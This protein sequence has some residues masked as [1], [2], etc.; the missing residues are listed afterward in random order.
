MYG[1]YAYSLDSRRFTCVG[2]GSVKLLFARISC[3]NAHTKS[4][5]YSPYL[6]RERKLANEAFVRKI[7]PVLYYSTAVKYAEKY[8]HVKRRAFLASVRRRE[9]ERQLKRGKAVSAVLTSGPH[10]LLCLFY[11][12]IGE[13]NKLKI[14]YSRL[15]VALNAYHI[16][17]NSEKSCA[18]YNRKHISLH[19]NI[20]TV[21]YILPHFCLFYNRLKQLKQN[22]WLNYDLSNRYLYY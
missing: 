22:L 1:V 8:R 6:T 19:V 10:P 11:G 2:R 7:N 15:R 17:V 5:A 9:I 14:G 21:P 13:S 16:A 3:R 12:K 18:V 20:N 4:A